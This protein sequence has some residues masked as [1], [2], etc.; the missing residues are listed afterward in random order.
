M[1]RETVRAM[2]D[3][4]QFSETA[5]RIA[6]WDHPLADPNLEDA[7]IVHKL[8]GL[9]RVPGLGGL[10]AGYRKKFRHKSWQ[11]M[12]ACSD[13][14]FVAFIVGT[15]GF[16]G[17]G[18]VYVVEPRTA[19]VASKFAITPLNRGTHLAASSASGQHRF[20]GSGLRIEIDNLD[21]GRRFHAR[22]KTDG[23]A[24]DLEFTSEPGDEHSAQCVPTPNGR[25]SYT[26]KFGALRVAGTISLGGRTIA[27]TRERALG[28]VDFTKA[29]AQRHAVWKWIALAG[30]TRAGKVVGINLVDPTPEAAFSENAAWIDGKRHPLANVHL[31]VG[32]LDD[33]RSP[34][35]LLADG[36]EIDMRAITHVEQ[37]L[38]VPLV[39]HRLRHVVGAF[40]GSLVLAGERHE[41][42]DV[43]GIAEDNDTWW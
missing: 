5:P 35:R 33:P 26:H 34:W 31:D 38:D 7:A 21:G 20:E 13:D 39:K 8:A 37:K 16:A 2:P 15:A 18:F 40:S 42:V 24:L 23:I 29:Y 27:L 14:V 36:L 25:W 30:R 3:L 22:A 4:V 43:V 11:Y 28:T 6:E 19:A 17:N 10:E 9:A 1:I 32:Q 12:T 41:L